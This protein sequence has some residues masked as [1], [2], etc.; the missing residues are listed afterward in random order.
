MDIAISIETTGRDLRYALRGFRRSPGF[1]LT[2]ILSLALGIG[3]SVSIFTVADSLLLRPLPYRDPSRLVMLWEAN[4]QRGVEHQVAS[5][6]NYLDWK[7]QAN[8]LRIEIDLDPA[9]LVRFGHELNV[10]ERSS[11]HQQGVAIFH[12]FL[13]RARTQ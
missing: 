13:G 4:R 9:C 8:S 5:P 12:R 2:A 7:A 11:N 6:G 10:G 3:A 1:A